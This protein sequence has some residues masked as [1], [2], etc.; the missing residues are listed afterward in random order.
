MEA[1][2][3]T[4]LYYYILNTHKYFVGLRYFANDFNGLIL[5]FTYC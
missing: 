2:M 1:C 3:K 5:S 4:D